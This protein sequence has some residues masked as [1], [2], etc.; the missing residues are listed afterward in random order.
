MTGSWE[1]Q[2]AAQGA[3]TGKVMVCT[4]FK[5]S[6]VYGEWALKLPRIL[7]KI[8]NGWE[9]ASAKG[10][11]VDHARNAIVQRTLES[12]C[13]WLFWLD[14]DVVPKDDDCVA[15]LLQHR[16]PI[17]SGLYFGK[18]HEGWFPAAWVKR[19]DKG[20]TMYSP[21]KP[22]LKDGLY[23][24]DCVGAG[25]MVVHRSV[26]EKMKPPWYLY[27]KHSYDEKTGELRNDDATMSEDF[28]FNIKAKKELNIRTIIDLSVKSDHCGIMKI[29]ADGVV[30]LTDP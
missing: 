20:K 21:L 8:P 15:R 24:V 16:Q 7:A 30:R 9:F 4:P 22:D 11:P 17:M 2:Q 14:C 29:C 1:G 25:F 10:M 28:W 12:G 19:E 6:V 13:E 26:Y 23:Q 5:E 18:K 3:G 27:T